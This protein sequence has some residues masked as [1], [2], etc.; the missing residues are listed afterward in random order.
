MQNDNTRIELVTNTFGKYHRQDI[1]VDSW[2]HLKKLFPGNINLNN[3]QFE[4]ERNTFVD[5]YD[6]VDTSFRLKNSSKSLVKGSTKKLPLV[7]E[8]IFSGFKYDPDYVLFTN[9]DVIL[10]P[11]LIEYI[12]KEQPDCMAISRMDIE[13]IESFDNIL[14]QDVKPVRY[15]IGGYDVFV[16]KRGWFQLNKKYFWS[17]F[18]LGA[19]AFD[20]VFA[21]L[22]VMFGDKFEMGNGF[23]PYAFH[24]WH[25]TASV[26]TP[27]PERDYNYKVFNKNPLFK[28]ANNII[29]HNIQYN[30]CKRKPWGRFL[31]PDEQEQ[32]RQK[33]FFNEMNLKDMNQ[34][35]YI[36][37]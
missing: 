12:L 16:M 27:S 5:H 4:D 14:R 19:P 1:A 35:R 33:K 31:I 17:N 32:N 2:R 8:I 9:S 20:P 28:I 13:H 6:D 34:I 11:H 21:G 36:T 7:S 18:L 26:D 23:P 15:E 25:G 3:F 30:L 37:D 10:M 29:F 24:I 22:M